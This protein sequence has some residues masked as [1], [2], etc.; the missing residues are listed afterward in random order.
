MTKPAPDKAEEAVDYPDR[1]YIGTFEHTA[2]FDAHL[3][4][5]GISLSLHRRGDADTR[6]CIRM[7]IHYFL[8]AA[9]LNDLAR[10][11]AMVPPDDAGHREALRS[12]ARALWF[13]LE[14]AARNAN[15]RGPN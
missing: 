13:A 3:D 2:R 6:K 7:H 1:L 12:S 14:P 15:A 5:N 8:F 9:I 4:G 10:T 11:V